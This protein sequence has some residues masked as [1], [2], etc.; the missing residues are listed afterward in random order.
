MKYKEAEESNQIPPITK[1]FLES[2]KQYGYKWNYKNCCI[3][4]RQF[5]RSV[6]TRMDVDGIYNIFKVHFILS[7]STGGQ[8]YSVGFLHGD[9]KLFKLSNID[10][11]SNL[12]EECISFTEI[13]NKISNREIISIKRFIEDSKRFTV[14][15]YK[16]NIHSIFQ[17]NTNRRVRGR[18][19]FLTEEYSE[20]LRDLIGQFKLI[21]RL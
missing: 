16:N 20:N 15:S 3:Q 6:V 12:V 10:N 14:V 9:S 18:Q 2:L 8:K 4:K 21:N 1:K 19:E 5:T 7:R 11:L 13:L 17:T